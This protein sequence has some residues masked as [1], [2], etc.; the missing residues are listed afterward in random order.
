MD[1]ASFGQISTT[2]TNAR[3]IQFAMKMMF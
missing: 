1:S 2:L 3:I